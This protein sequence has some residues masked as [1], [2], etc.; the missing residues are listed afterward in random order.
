MSDIPYAGKFGGAGKV[1]MTLG[2]YIDEVSER[3][4]GSEGEREREREGKREG[5]RDEG[6]KGGRLIYAA[7]PTAAPTPAEGMKSGKTQLAVLSAS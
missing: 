6:M 3:E 7:V 1:D 2:D 4:R 5:G